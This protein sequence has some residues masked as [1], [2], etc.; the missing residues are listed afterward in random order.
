MNKFHP[1]REQNEILVVDQ[2]GLTRDALERLLAFDGYKTCGS[3]TIAESKAMMVWRRPDL[4]IVDIRLPDG[5]GL[6]LIGDICGA[7]QLPVIIYANRNS[8]ADVIA[9]LEQGADDYIGK[10]C[11]VAEMLARIRAVLRR[12]GRSME[13]RDQVQRKV[14]FGDVTLDCVRQTLVREGC[15]ATNLSRNEFCL[16]KALL[17][18][19]Y[20]VLCRDLLREAIW[21]GRENIARGTI[22]TEVCRLRQKLGDNQRKSPLISA[23]RGRGYVLDAEVSWE[24]TF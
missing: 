1:R 7:H 16:L 14:C 5:N 21:P 20:K 4:A 6:D 17:E 11:G 2:D 24:Y 18:N 19:P 15:C 12:R 8:E 3:G 9:G 23:V 22:R 10:S 13:R